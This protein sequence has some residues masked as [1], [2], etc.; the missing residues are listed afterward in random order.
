MVYVARKGHGKSLSPKIRYSANRCYE[1]TAL[2]C[3]EEKKGSYSYI[4]VYQQ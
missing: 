2:Q 4:E 3:K 1:N